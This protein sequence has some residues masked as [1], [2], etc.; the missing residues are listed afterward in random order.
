MSKLRIFVSEIF[1]FIII[2]NIFD[3]YMSVNYAIKKLKQFNLKK[4]NWGTYNF[5]KKKEKI[6]GITN[7][8]TICELR[9]YLTSQIIFVRSKYLKK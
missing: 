8:S 2:L 1:H 5:S 7:L 9:T 3:S 4:N 6:A